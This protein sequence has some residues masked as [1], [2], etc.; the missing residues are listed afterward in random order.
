MQSPIMKLPVCLSVLFIMPAESNLKISKLKLN[1]ATLSVN[2]QYFIT[3]FLNRHAAAWYKAS[4]T[5]IPGPC[6][7]EKRIY[8]A[9]V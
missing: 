1:Q 8:Q 5:V 7:I 9:A 6:L 4:A 3:V 2:F